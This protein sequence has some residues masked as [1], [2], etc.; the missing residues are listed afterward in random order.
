MVRD[1][2][3]NN[4]WLLD[5]KFM[6]FRSVLSEKEMVEVIAAISHVEEQGDR[7]R[8]DIAMVFSADP[9]SVEKVDV[10]VVEVKRRAVSDKDTT[11]AAVQLLK[12]ARMLIDHCPNIQRM[13]YYALVRYRRH[14][15]PV[16]AGRE[17]G[18]A[19]LKGARVP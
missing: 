13:W 6:T 14:A 15:R 19:V 5:D 3:R 1:I 2:Y 18:A 17:V 10:V 12:R 16:A 9:S 11:Y 7:T 4:V 8:P